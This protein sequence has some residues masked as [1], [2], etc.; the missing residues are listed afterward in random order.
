MQPRESIRLRTVYLEQLKEWLSNAEGPNLI[1]WTEATKQDNLLGMAVSFDPLRYFPPCGGECCGWNGSGLQTCLHPHRVFQLIADDPHGLIHQSKGE[2]LWGMFDIPQCLSWE[3]GVPT[4]QGLS[5]AC[6]TLLKGASKQPLFEESCYKLP[7]LQAPLGT[8]LS[9]KTNEWA[10]YISVPHLIGTA[11]YLLTPHQEGGLPEGFRSSST[12]CV[13]LSAPDQDHWSI[14]ADK[15]FTKIVKLLAEELLQRQE[16]AEDKEEAEEKEEDTEEQGGE[17]AAT[18]ATTAELSTSTI[19]AMEINEGGDGSNSGAPPPHSV[20]TQ[21][22][23]EHMMR[24]IAFEAK[25]GDI[26]FP[27]TPVGGPP[28]YNHK[29][30]VENHKKVEEVMK[31]ICSLHLQAIYNA[32]AVRQVD[33]ILAELLMAQFTRVNQ[34]MGK[35][36][37]TSLWELFTIMEASGETL[38]GELKTALGPKVSN[39]VSYNLQQVM[40]SHNSCLYMSLTKV[41]VFLDSGTWEGCNFLEDL[42][43]SLQ[44]NKELKKLVTTLSGQISAFED[45]V[46]EL[47]L[48]EEL[49]EEEVALHVNLALIATRPIIGNYFNRVLEGL[50][51]SL[52]IKVHEDEDPPR[53][54]QEGLERHL[55]EK[56]QRSSASA[57]SLEGCESRGLHV[58]Y[59][60]EYA[61]SEKGP[62]VPALSS[63]ALPNLLDVI[64][65]LR[66]GMSTPSDEAKPSEEQ[67][68]LLES[69]AVKGVPKS[70]KTKDVYQRF[71]NILKVRPHIWDPAPTLK[72][73]DPKGTHPYLLDG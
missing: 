40:E 27:I 19:S 12:L 63:M 68:D 32:G 17:A 42:V 13:S 11:S 53:S 1:E 31:K 36:L 60:L 44:T 7:G 16:E 4:L 6:G 24:D 14:H 8:W 57:P 59:S 39:L 64:D 18:A 9:P 66:L 21:R 56:L 67:Q 49:A 70:S 3:W 26:I 73:R 55:A 34:M 35:D 22:P 37:N 29:L 54:T 65:H 45:H 5:C 15:K 30:L 20:S 33:W 48:S 28:P 43:K 71:M 58:G 2:A 72:L 47:A 23:L 62:S 52:G 10:R 50:M 69:L 46:W 38:L 41:L 25:D 61:D 51:G